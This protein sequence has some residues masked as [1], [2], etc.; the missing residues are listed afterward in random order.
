MTCSVGSPRTALFPYFEVGSIKKS[1]TK[2]PIMTRDATRENWSQP[3]GEGSLTVLS[4]LQN[5]SFPRV[6]RI[7]AKLMGYAQG[8]DIF[9][10]DAMNLP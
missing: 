3:F 5:S 10:N 9:T 6:L 1:N 7:V 8:S 2:Q 4:T